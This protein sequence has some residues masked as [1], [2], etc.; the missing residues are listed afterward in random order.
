MR[1]TKAGTA[2]GWRIQSWSGTARRLGVALGALLCV[3]AAAAGV[4]LSGLREMQAG[5]EAVR[6]REQAVL[7]ALQLALS[8]VLLPRR[9]PAIAPDAS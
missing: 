8:A 2:G 1:T 7:L 4:A 6:Q 9:E 5:L 3:F